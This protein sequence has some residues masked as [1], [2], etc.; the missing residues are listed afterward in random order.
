[1]LTN[2]QK[3]F[4]LIKMGYE[5]EANCYL[6][7]SS[8]DSYGDSID[9]ILMQK[10]K[11][12]TDTSELNLPNTVSELLN[13]DLLSNFKFLSFE[14]IQDSY[15]QVIN[16]LKQNHFDENILISA[17]K[18][19]MY[20]PFQPDI[21]NLV[22]YIIK[23]IDAT[24][25]L[26]ESS[27]SSY[28]IGFLIRFICDS[29]FMAQ[30]YQIIKAIYSEF[31]DVSALYEYILSNQVD[32]STESFDI[33]DIEYA[34]FTRISINS[35]PKFDR[36]SIGTIFLNEEKYI[37]LNL[38]QH[39]K[40][41]DEWILV[42][43][44][45]LGYPP[46]KVS[47]K[48]TSLDRSQT[49]IRIFPDRFKKICLVEHG[50]TTSSGEDAKSE[51]RN[52]YMKRCTGDCLL[53]L[54]ADE[55]YLPA[56][57]SHTLSKFDDKSVYSITLPQVHFWKDL[58]KFIVGEYYDISHTRFFRFLPGARYI[59][60][61]NFPEVN[62]EFLHKINNRKVG[63]KVVETFPESNTFY[64]IDDCCFH[65]G[66]AKDFDDMRDKSD[67]YI[68]R[69]EDKTRVSTTQ[70]RA[71]WFDDN[72]PAKCKVRSWGGVIPQALLNKGK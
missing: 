57:L 58:T 5:R 11:N 31:C 69:G 29:I 20:S 3:A 54:D 40:Y 14:D 50:W 21:C 13:L 2:I 36:L 56:T 67:Y 25:L 18:V 35:I 4:Q 49:I 10:L 27:E 71:A 66:F 64:Y 43:G 34:N 32:H 62:G 16:S 24:I 42:E 39:Y 55:F 53:V 30:N 23:R 37:G 19:F 26:E 7:D 8:N 6:L 63:R 48:G 22:Y 41:C 51:L 17:L 28:S 70:S 44:A 33:C 9:N 72:L 68:N 15:V 60:N 47:E 52:E 46:R 45:C 65:L 59:Q 61:H 1:M 38:I 12:H